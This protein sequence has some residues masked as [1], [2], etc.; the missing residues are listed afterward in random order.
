MI[1]ACGAPLGHETLC[2]RACEALRQ[3]RRLALAPPAELS[4]VERRHHVGSD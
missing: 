1:G 3:E 4:E 2:A